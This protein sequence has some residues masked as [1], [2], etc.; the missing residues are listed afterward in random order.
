VP[1]L[2]RVRPREGLPPGAAST[3]P[4]DP[5]QTKR[6]ERILAT[7]PSSRRTTTASHAGGHRAIT[8]TRASAARDRL[9]GL[10]AAGLDVVLEAFLDGMAVGAG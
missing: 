8:S 6:L 2:P 7:A 5:E 3:M 1:G 10:A 4:L 9:S